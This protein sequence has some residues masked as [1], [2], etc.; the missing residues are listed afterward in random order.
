MRYHILTYLAITTAMGKM[1]TSKINSNLVI[2]LYYCCLQNEN[3]PG[4]L[5]LLQALQ[6]CLRDSKCNS[7]GC[8]DI[9]IAKHGF[10]C[11]FSK[12]QCLYLRKA[13]KERNESATGEKKLLLIINIHQCNGKA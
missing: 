9:V 1:E 4:Y 11:F 8:Y 7:K 10:V 13:F 2:D 5:N 12:F 3:V 6:G